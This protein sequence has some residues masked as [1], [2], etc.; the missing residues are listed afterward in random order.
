MDKLLTQSGGA[1]HLLLGNEAIVRGAL[2]A[3]MAFATCYPGTP[4]SEVPD[5]LYRLRKQ[6]PDQVKYYFEYSTNEKVALECAAGA[7]VAGLRTLCTMK[8]VGL[9][10]AADPLMTLAYTG[11]NAGLVVLTADDPSMFSSQNEQDN[12]YYARLSGLPMLE[13]KG[14][15]ELK[16]MTKYAFD[17]SEELKSPVLLRTTTRVNHAREGV[18]YAKLPKV[19]QT[20]VFKK[21]PMDFVTVPAVSRKKHLRLLEI[22]DKS[23]AISEASEYN[24]VTGRGSYGIITTAVCKNYVRD[25]LKDLGALNQIKVLNL[26]FTW[27]LP[28]KKMARFLKSV[29]KVLVV[30]ELEPLLEDAVRSICQKKGIATE[31]AGKSA[32]F[33]EVTVDVAPPKFFS[34]AFEYNPRLVRQVV[35][36][37]FGLKAKF[38]T[39]LKLDDLPV[40]PGRPP[41]LCAGC[42]HRATY[43]AVKEVVGKDGIHP[44]DI[45]CYTLGLLPPIQMA[46]FL[47]CMGSSVSSAGGFARAT[48]KKVVSFIG[49]STFFHSGMTGLVNAV[50]NNL[51]FTLV[52]LDNGTTA[53]TGHQ[54]HPGVDTEAI[55]DATTHIDI[56]Q[57][58]RG[59]GVEHVTTIKPLK[60]KAAIKAIEEAVNH[61]GVSVVI[62]KE[63]CPLFA[64]RVVP[65]TR[66]PFEVKVDKCKGHM[67]CINKIA[68]PAMYV[69][70]GQAKINA[71]QCVGCALCAQICPENAILPV[72]EA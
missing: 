2:E 68:C 65:R 23:Q 45:G 47:V 8:H 16:E 32:K 63:L 5:T 66:K 35:G 60:T 56:E 49:D 21:S 53:M 34:R 24:K 28:E 48:D 33:P 57:V 54:P 17:L 10:V 46:D 61:E 42:P 64:K 62:S 38:T 51:N 71:G 20:S 67:D 36:K 19:K 26:G 40:L 55:G 27:P 43:Y 15:A 3:G 6:N 14:P 18:T 31:I 9:N 1:T 22:Y 4:S 30:E 29:E 70:K 58:V 69:E 7:A 37:T 39:P 59:L 50:H 12:R 11:V 25:A 72:K 44:T 41:N 52:I 13:A